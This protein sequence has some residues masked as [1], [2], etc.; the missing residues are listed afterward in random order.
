MVYTETERLEAIKLAKK[1]YYETHKSEIRNKDKQYQK[2][3]YTTDE[4]Y[5]LRKLHQMKTYRETHKRIKDVTLKGRPEDVTQKE[6]VTP[7]EDVT[8]KE[9]VTHKGRPEDVIIN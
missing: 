1:K 5:R 6:D 3:R 8:Q 9:D 4:E 7:K 2:T